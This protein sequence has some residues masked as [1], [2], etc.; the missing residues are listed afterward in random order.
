MKYIGLMSGTS[1]DAIDVALLEFSDERAF[2][3]TASH[4]HP[5]PAGVRDEAQA[6]TRSLE[7]ELERAAELDVAMGEVFAEA[8]LTLL[9]REQLRPTEI[10]AIGSHGQTLRHRPEARHPFSIQIGNPAVI[11]E[12]TGITTV[13]DFRP[14]D[15][16][17]GGQGAPLAPAFHQ[18][19]FSQRGANRAIVNI[20][21]IANITWLSAD[22]ETVLGFDTGPGN[23]LLDNW[24]HKHQQLAYDRDGKWGS[25]GNL[26]PGLLEVLLR[27][28]YFNRPPPKST[29]REYFNLAWLEPQLDQPHASLSPE[30]IQA[31]LVQLTAETIAVGLRTLLPG[32]VDEVY[33]CGGGAYHPGIMASLSERMAPVPVH[34]TRALGLDPEWVEAAAFAWLASRTLNAQ[35]GNLPTVTGARQ[36]VILGGIWHANRAAMDELDAYWDGG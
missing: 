32:E 35:P 3:L 18:A 24:I 28:S 11:A 8:V 23:T 6:L 30:D 10:H 22:D 26:H 14:R 31:T 13:A 4:V 29:G 12:R 33:V 21:G 17:A 20:G 19:R 1:V 5:S 7:N 9:Q 16:A 36:A 34:T 27:D 25:Q 2:A 15:M